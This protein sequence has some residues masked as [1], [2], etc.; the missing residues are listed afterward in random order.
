M[1]MGASLNLTSKLFSPVAYLMSCMG[2][3][4][5]IIG[6]LALSKICLSIYFSCNVKDENLLGCCF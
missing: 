4:G 3:A 2:M 6:E 1:P 5:T